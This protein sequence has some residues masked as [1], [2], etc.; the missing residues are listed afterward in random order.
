MPIV[1]EI[2]VNKVG[3]RPVLVDFQNGKIKPGEE[4]NLDSALYRNIEKE[5]VVAVTNCN[6]LYTGIVDN[7]NDLYNNFILVH[8]RKSGKV[9]L[10]QVDCCPVSPLLDKKS[11]LMD[12]SVSKAEN[13]MSELK[14]QFGSKKT[15]RSVEQQERLKMNIST[16]KEQL[17]KTIT[18]IKIDE[19]DMK[20]VPDENDNLYRPKINRDAST[21]EQVYNLEDLVPTSVLDTLSNEALNLVNSENLEEF[22]FLPFVTNNITRILKSLDD[23][24]IH[25]L[26][27]FLYIHYLM[28]F[29]NT[30]FKHVTKKFVVCDKSTEVNN[31]ILNNYSSLNAGHRTRPSGFKDKALCYILV[32]AAIVMDYE[33]DV[34]TISKALKI[35]TK[36]VTNTSRVLG[37]SSSVKNGISL[38]SLKLPLPAQVLMSPK[39]KKD[40]R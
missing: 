18:D 15:K 21:R 32:L 25:K 27:I 20:L 16:V 29:M 35:G 17:E 10:I 33:V 12:T 7:E 28:K 19:T 38:V 40:K 31:H 23:N 5:T 3:F 14:K 13:S 1:N 30:P 37:F 4:G 6:M 11:K 22:G 39:K 2:S 36:K 24:K 26:T 9:R 8:N 34:E